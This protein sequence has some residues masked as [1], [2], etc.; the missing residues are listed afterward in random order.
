[1]PELRIGGV[2]EGRKADERGQKVWAAAGRSFSGCGARHDSMPKPE[3]DAANLRKRTLD[4]MPG[5]ARSEE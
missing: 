1:L 4:G 2:V 3:P 5:R